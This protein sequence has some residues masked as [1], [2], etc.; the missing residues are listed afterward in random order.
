MTQA[1]TQWAEALAS[2]AIPEEILSKAPE[3]PWIHPPALFDVPSV[4]PPTP[5]HDRAREA[6]PSG[7]S[8][9]DVGCG[10]GIAAFAL[11]PKAGTVIGVDHQ[12][13]MLEMFAAHADELG[14]AS[15]THFGFW[16]ALAGETP[17]ADVVTCHHVVYNVADI[18]PFLRELD[19]HARGRVVIEMPQRH[20]LWNRRN[21]WKHF[22]DIER[23]ED[24]TPEMLLDVLSEMGIVAH[25]HLWDGQAFKQLDID[26]E[27]EF[28]RIRLCLPAD[29]DEEIREF[30][31]KETPATVR[32]LATIWWDKA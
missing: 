11:V 28:T 17:A 15:E 30:L 9:L 22:W 14:V 23:P 1:A 7:G 10:G 25:M 2:W 24:P 3:S 19:A 8:V 21:A 26:T 13:E 16:P 12:S 5:S 4:I 32:P 6:L 29:R 20:P 27:V 18:E 31:L